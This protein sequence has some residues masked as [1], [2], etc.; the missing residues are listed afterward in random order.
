MTLRARSLSWMKL[1]KFLRL[2]RPC[3]RELEAE[4]SLPCGVLGPVDF[5]ALERLAASWAA[6]MC[7]VGCGLVSVG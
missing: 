2:Y 4:R 7:W 3:W 1:S 5:L 6:E